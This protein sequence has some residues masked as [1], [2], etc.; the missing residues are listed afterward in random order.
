[1]VLFLKIG[2]LQLNVVTYGLVFIL[3]IRS[4]VFLET[5]GFLSKR[6]RDPILWGRN[7][8][9]S[10]LVTSHF[11]TSLYAAFISGGQHSQLKFVELFPRGDHGCYHRFGHVSSMYR[12][13]PFH[14]TLNTNVITGLDMCQV[15]TEAVHSKAL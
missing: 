13:S 9:P 7:K 8:V 4:D 14:S 5:N 2:S 1:M 12:S 15:C 10:P 11:L 6:I 3:L